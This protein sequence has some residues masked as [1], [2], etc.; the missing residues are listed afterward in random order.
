MRVSII[1]SAGRNGLITNINGKTYNNM[2]I[3][4]NNYLNMIKKK[5]Q[6][7]KENDLIV[8]SGGAALSDHIAV[9][10]FLENKI[11]KLHLYLP[12]DFDGFKF[13]RKNNFNDKTAYTSNLHHYTFSKQ[14]K[15]N[16]YNEL[17][18][19]IEKGATYSVSSGFFERNK[20]I[21]DTDYLIAFS[22]NNDNRIT[23][24]DKGENGNIELTGGT[25]YTWN[26][27][28]KYS[29]VRIHIPITLMSCDFKL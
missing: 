7:T 17:K 23:V 24:Y 28:K 27:S 8:C 5:H 12:C 6:L 19:A 4:A 18:L 25:K 22:F 1:G 13:Y 16:S 3:V 10:L 15:I 26:Y 29:P 9:S 20:L 14:L 11:S 21:A 2:K